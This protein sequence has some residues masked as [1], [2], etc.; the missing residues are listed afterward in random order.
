MPLSLGNISALQLTARRAWNSR[1]IVITKGEQEDPR[2]R[3]P[4]RR[5]HPRQA[6]TDKVI[7]VGRDLRA[8]LSNSPASAVAPSAQLSESSLGPQDHALG[9]H[10]LARS[11]RNGKSN[12]NYSAKTH[13]TK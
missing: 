9:C 8:H 7:R 3:P 12:R 1:T 6:P 2:H 10:V 13:V 5:L 11:L 4:P